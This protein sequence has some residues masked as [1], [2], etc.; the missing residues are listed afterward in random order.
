MSFI[1]L[2]VCI[3]HTRE[4]RYVKLRE[5]AF[6][7]ALLDPLSGLTHAAL[8]GARKQSVRD[9]EVLLSYSVAES[10]K[11][12]GFV[13]E[14]DYIKLI[15]QWHE[16]SDGRGLSDVQRSNFNAEMF[17]FLMEEL[18]P[19]QTNCYNFCLLDINMQVSD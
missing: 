8:T 18:I 10:M 1:F 3:G 14:S 17:R 12:H 9:A 11:R 7:T 19:G 15:A 5:S 13:F 2:F 4:L 6:A 16:A